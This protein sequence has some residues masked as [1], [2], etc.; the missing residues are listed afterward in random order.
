MIAFIKYIRNIKKS[1]IGIIDNYIIIMGHLP[2]RQSQNE[3]D[4]GYNYGK[5]GIEIQYINK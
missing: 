3:N 5:Q 1:K 2:V 4:Q